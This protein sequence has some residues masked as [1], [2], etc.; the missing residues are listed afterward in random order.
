MVTPPPPSGRRFPRWGDLC[1]TDFAALDPARAVAVLPVAATEQ[2]GPHLP[3]S[4]DVDIL[5][6]ILAAAAPRLP[7]GMPVWALPT[8]PV[9]LSPEHQR[10]AGTLTLNP[11]T[12]IALWRELGECVARAGVRKL[13]LFNSHGGHAG[14]L[15]VVGRELRSR[16][17][18]LVV[19]ASWFNLP[20]TDAQGQD[21]NLRISADEHRFGIHAGQVETSMMLA[22]DPGRVRMDRAQAFASTS[23][24]RAEIYPVLGNG[25]SAKM[26]WQTQDYH[27][28]GAVGD[29]SSATAELGHALID[30]SG[31]ALAQLLGEL[32]A[33][34]MSTLKQGPDFS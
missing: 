29:A 2:H 31:R 9:G 25:R 24:Q 19:S 16:C 7:P 18:L 22:I 4:V 3:L 12:V 8:Q 17:D 34:P 28:Q 33:L 27:P 10:F 11:E 5:E 20:L 14:L 13:L 30:A 21:L 15:D 6:A 23:R 26:A 1:T 32:V